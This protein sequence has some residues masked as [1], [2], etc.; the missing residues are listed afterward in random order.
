MYNSSLNMYIGIMANI[1]VAD[2]RRN[3][4]DVIQRAQQEPVVIARRGLPE[5]VVVSAEHFERLNEALE[6]MADVAA[7]DEAV[8][9]EGDN[10]PWEQVKADLGWE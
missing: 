3:F 2:A 9:E 10:L 6:Q 8:A 4:A 7:F 1:G 5:A